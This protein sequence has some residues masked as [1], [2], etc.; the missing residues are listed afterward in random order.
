MYGALAHNINAR[1]NEGHVHTQHTH[2]H[3][4]TTSFTHQLFVL[5]LKIYGRTP[6]QSPDTR[7]LGRNHMRGRICTLGTVRRSFQSSLHGPRCR[8]CGMYAHMLMLSP[9]FFCQ[10]MPRNHN[11]ARNIVGLLF[12]DGRISLTWGPRLLVRVDVAFFFF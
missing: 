12:S 7:F 8:T 9:P 4:H 10:Q 11:L 2:T 5:R 1:T 3:I 6:L